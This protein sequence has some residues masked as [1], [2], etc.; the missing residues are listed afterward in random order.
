MGGV[1]HTGFVT[2]VGAGPGDPDLLTVG[3]LTALRSA[4]VVVH[5]A[6]LSPRLLDHCPPGAE[7]IDAGK[8]AGAHFM[9][10]DEINALLVARASEG[11]RVVRLKGGDPFVFGRGGEEALALRA[12]G[13]PFAVIPGVTSAVAVPAYAGIPVT[14]RGLARSFAVVSGAESNA[15]A[16]DWAALARL[17]T[18]VVLMGAAGL[19]DIAARLIASGG[20]PRTPAAAIANGTLPSQ[21]KV[22]ADLATIAEAVAAAGLPTPLLTVIGDVVSLAPELAWRD[23]LPLAG[24]SVVITRTREQA[25]QLRTAL[26]CLGARVIEAPVLEIRY[27]AP[28]L[29]TDE[30]V[31][32]RWDWVVFASQNGVTGFF[33]ALRAAGRDARAL[34]STKVAAVGAATAGVLGRYGVIADFVPSLA[35]AEHLAAELPRVEGA[36]ILLPSGSLSD[37]R[38]SDVLRARGGHVERVQVYETLSAKLDEPA[39]A[40]LAGAAAITFASASSAAFLA[41]ALGGRALSSGTKLCAIG[42]QAAEATRAAFGRVDAVAATPSIAGLAAAVVEALS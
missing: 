7:R 36:R 21:A 23:A 16:H 38:L 6:L 37:Q 18:L 12:A 27:A 30:R 32:S 28:E 31:A 22:V 10:Q 39:V 25:S 34:A 4:E 42:P 26:E 35:D 3:G 24:K 9:S 1:P 29:T 19:A 41:K 17:D 14:H 33:E 11:K 2:L 13:I 20:D 8:R 5:D 40:A 15:D